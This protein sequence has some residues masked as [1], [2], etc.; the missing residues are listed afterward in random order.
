MIFFIQGLWSNYQRACW[1]TESDSDLIKGR[2]WEKKVVEND[3]QAVTKGPGSHANS[4]QAARG[5]V[6]VIFACTQAYF[7]VIPLLTHHPKMPDLK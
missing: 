5:G 7:S 6:W 2:Y 4:Y 1:S 3:T